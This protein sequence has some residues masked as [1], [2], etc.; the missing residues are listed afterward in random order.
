LHWDTFKRMGNDC[1]RCG[2]PLTVSGMFCAHCGAPQLVYEAGSEAQEGS[3][4]P[5]AAPL[6]DV[7]WKVAIGAAVTFA[8]PVGVLCA[9]V[10]VLSWGWCLWVVGGSIAAVGLYQR[11]TAGR[12][13]ARRTG[14][15]IGTIVGLM[16]AV[17]ASAFNAGAL[18]VVRYLLHGGDSMDKV[19]QTAT[20]Q[21]WI[22]AAPLSDGFAHYV[23]AP[24]ADTH[25]TL[26]FM[27][28]P[29]GRA[30]MALLTAVMTSIGITL[31]SML[32]G[33]IGTRIFSGRAPSP[34]KS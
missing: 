14:V 27:L 13:L 33:A 26:Q 4:Q 5:A 11:R 7:H 3:S 9:P 2:S 17:V 21:A 19:Y 30:A 20:E 24:A 6:R 8:V 22:A 28:S 1:H 12:G 31:F 10:Q 34:E 16:A 23:G 25:Q 32:G 18:V 15:R 29:D